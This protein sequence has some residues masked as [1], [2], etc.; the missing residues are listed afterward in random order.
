MFLTDFQDYSELSSS[1]SQSAA[2]L[3][4]ISLRQEAAEV[5]E[6][7]EFIRPLIEQVILQPENFAGVLA[8]SLTQRTVDKVHSP[9]KLLTLFLGAYA[10]DQA[11]LS[12]AADDLRAVTSRD[13]AATGYLLP[14]MFFKGFHALQTHRVAHWLWRNGRFASALFLQSRS[15]ALYGVDIHPAARIGSGIMIDH[16]TGV[17]IGETAVIE[18]DVSLLHGVTLGG[19]GKQQG[20]RHPKIR[21]GV[22]IGAGAKVL[23]NIEV[24][25][26]ACVAA[27]SVVLAPVPPHTTVAGVPARVVGK[28]RCERPAMEMEQTL[29]DFGG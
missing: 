25:E 13:P 1:P 8:A 27:G 19:T 4:W 9:E 28:P 12:A 22:M 23:G 21:R 2:F 24:G 20:D 29:T 7:E 18:D 15:S 17:V 26:G 16:A 6:R 10:D 11:L 5:A 3:V 14:L